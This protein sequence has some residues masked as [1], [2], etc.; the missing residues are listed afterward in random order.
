MLHLLSNDE[1][2]RL[3]EYAEG[4]RIGRVSYIRG[5]LLRYLQM[6]G[7]EQGLAPSKSLIQKINREMDNGLLEKI[8]CNM[9][10]DKISLQDLELQYDMIFRT[11][12]EIRKEE[13]TVY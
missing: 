12:E 5:I 2:K 9:A 11:D 13:H 8:L 4:Y 3:Q 6:K 10:G 1:D 7:R